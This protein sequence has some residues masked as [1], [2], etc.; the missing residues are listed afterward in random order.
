MTVIA[1]ITEAA[2]VSKI[3]TH[4]GLP[5]GPPALS[6]ARGPAQLAL[7][8]AASGLARPSRPREALSRFRG[9]PTATGAE[10][11]VELFELHEPED[12]WGA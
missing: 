5:S 12:D 9:P 6:P 2:V 1:Y 8:E 7:F 10:L 4:L 3:L 11:V